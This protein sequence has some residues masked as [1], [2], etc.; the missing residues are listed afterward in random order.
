MLGIIIASIIIG[1][2][3]FIYSAMKVSSICARLEEEENE[4]YELIYG[5][6]DKNS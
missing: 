3:L 6:D 2:L 5:T 4:E 1:V